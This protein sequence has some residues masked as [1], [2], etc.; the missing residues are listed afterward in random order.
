MLQKLKTLELQTVSSLDLMN[1]KQ[2]ERFF[3]KALDKT[4][5]I[6]FSLKHSQAGMSAKIPEPRPSELWKKL[7][8][9]P[10]Q[11][12]IDTES[13]ESSLEFEASFYKSKKTTEV[14]IDVNENSLTL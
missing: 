8:I 5:D 1:L 7:G 9:P 3:Y 11:E 6:Q 4:K 12:N 2:L 14:S 13:D 10:Q